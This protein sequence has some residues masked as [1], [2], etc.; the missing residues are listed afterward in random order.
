MNKILVIAVVSVG[1]ASSC[2]RSRTD[3]P[4]TAGQASDAAA[5]AP[6][7]S[8]PSPA[9]APS[10]QTHKQKWSWSFEQDKLDQP[11][12]GFS[13]GRTGGG[14]PGRWLVRAEAGSNLLAQLDTDDTNFRFP[15]AVA[16]EP[17]LQNVRVSVRCKPISGKVDQACGLV[18]RYRDENDYLLTRAN[19]L[20]G[21]IRLY[22]VKHG[23]RDEIAD[24]RGPVTSNVWHD[25]RLEVVGDRMQVF[26]DG[27]R[28]IEQRDDTFREAGQVGVWTKADS[29][30]Y[31]A[32]LSAEAL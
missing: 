3:T 13:F 12:A 28:V 25:F 1:A 30:T 20:E 16:S 21:N 27:K 26:W 9:A 14:R 11:P 6:A 2:H 8:A 22:T 15:V 5:N 31:F 23:K 32:D 29:V 19:A 4:S 18:A 10:T 24:H 17:K 7:P